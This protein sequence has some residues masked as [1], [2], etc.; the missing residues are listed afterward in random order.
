MPVFPMSHF[1]WQCLRV[2]KRSKTPPTG[3]MLRFSPSRNTKDGTFL[4]DLVDRGLLRRVTG[5]ATK[6][7]EATYALTERGQHA[8][9]FG[10]SKMPAWVRPVEP[11]PAGQPKAVLKSKAGARG[12]K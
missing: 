5:T 12:S 3:R 6:P 9:E 10:E 7:F 11:V 1:T 8:A 4:N 2:A